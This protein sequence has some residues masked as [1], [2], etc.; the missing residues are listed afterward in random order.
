MTDNIFL[1][2]AQDSLQNIQDFDTKTLEREELG[3]SYNFKVAM[4]NINRLLELF[5][6]LP[7]TLLDELPE[8]Q[9]NIVR[10][11]ADNVLDLFTRVL[12]FDEMQGNAANERDVIITDI[13]EYYKDAFS[14]LILLISY[15]LTRT[16]DFQL[17]E[18]ESKQVLSNIKA[19]VQNTVDEIM[20][21]KTESS[22][23]LSEIKKTAAEQG[24]SQQAIYFSEEAERHEKRE[25]NWRRLT[26]GW[27]GVLIAYGVGSFFIHKLPILAPSGI[28]EAINFIASKILIF[29]VLTYMLILSARNFLSHKHNAVVN[30][31]RQNALV[32]FK[33]LVDASQGKETQDII[34][35]HASSC[36]FSP[37]DTGYTKH[38][39]SNSAQMPH[40]VDL[41]P[42]TTARMEE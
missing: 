11:Q 37:Q 10:F 24:V 7:V 28:P 33:A 32:T 30:K 20:S 4:P 19:D 36:I 18:T 15:G 3:Q 41:I 16:V 12:S 23:I 1:R 26:I 38:G 42:K 21:L 17:I 2:S 35:S 6:K 14:N 39:G 31:H 40:I 25:D 29:A 5:K 27:A 22:E 9:L 13:A 34:L 8:D